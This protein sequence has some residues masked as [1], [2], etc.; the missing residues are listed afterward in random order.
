MA[1]IQEY[2]NKILS[3]RYGKDVRQSIHDG[4]S[5]INDEVV[6]YGTTA[7]EAAMLAESAMRDAENARDATYNYKEEATNAA[8][9]ASTSTEDA[10]D[11]AADA[12]QSAA[13]ASTYMSYA[14]EYA[15]DAQDYA[16]QAER[17][18]EGL[19]GT[20]IPMGTITFAELPDTSKS[21][22]L[23]NISNE[24]TTTARFK[25]GSGRTIPA[26]SNVFYTADGYW[27]VLAGSP[28]TGVKGS[29]ESS[30]RRGNVNITPANIGLGNVPNVSTNNQT[31]TY[32]ASTS[33]TAL[34]SGEKL[35]VAFG[36]IAK[37]IADL[38]SHLADTVSH[39]TALERTA[40]NNAKDKSDVTNIAYGTCTTAG[41]VSEKVVTLDGNDNWTLKKGAIIM[42]KFT[43]SNSASNVTLNVNGTGGKQIW[44]GTSVH[45]GNSAVVSGEQGRYHMYVYDGTYWA[46]VSHGQDANTTYTNQVLGQG[47][48][49]C[50]TAAATTAKVATLSGYTK[51]L[52]GIV[53]VKFTYAVPANATLNINNRGASAIYYR[54]SAITAGVIKAGN[55]AT[56]MYDGSYYQLLTIDKL[57]ASD[58]GAVSTG[59]G[60]LTGQI[61]GENGDGDETWYI[62]E[63]GYAQLVRLNGTNVPANPK[64]T[65]TVVSVTN[66]HL[67]K[68]L[69][70]NASAG[71]ETVLDTISVANG[72][73]LVS[74]N[75]RSDATFTGRWFTRL[76]SEG[77]WKL[78]NNS[79]TTINYTTIVT[80][81]NGTIPINFMPDNAV[82]GV[83]LYSDIGII[84]L[85]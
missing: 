2:L 49:T 35:S 7:S 67:L 12:S 56:F 65:D 15:L 45:T 60:T 9:S 32:T 23:Y 46:W 53:A 76:N 75:I 5:A 73:Y 26:G 37:A 48:A 1:N 19:G 69:T 13:S 77:D 20:L 41:N 70:V 71:T 62:D 6:D 54:G 52:Y 81:T 61:S 72:T 10:H 11:Y 40:W 59:G 17:I 34:T 82:S 33:L 36:K 80:V 64:F 84:K 24:F 39:I 42:V 58:V 28:V 14:E 51:T 8:L 78:F 4:I 38:I 3:A 68:N 31:P 16:E 27:D 43:N 44:Y 57:T 21:G 50:T 66:G 63:D 25:E 74:V 79:P 18:A 29:A 55:T 30:Y 22:Y 47:Y 83:T 85:F